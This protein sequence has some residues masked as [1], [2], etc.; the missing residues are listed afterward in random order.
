MLRWEMLQTILF[1]QDACTALCK[2]VVNQPGIASV[3]FVP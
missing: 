1:E 2:G 3:F